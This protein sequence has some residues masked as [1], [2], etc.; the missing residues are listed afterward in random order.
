MTDNAP[1]PLACILLVDADGQ[2]L[3]QLRDE[4][5]PNWPGVWGTPGGHWE[6]GETIE[7]TA[8]RELAEE[9]GLRPDAPLRLFEI[10]ELPE[11]GRVKH[12]FCGPTSA[13]QE[14][15]VVGEGAAIVFV[16]ADQL[17]DGRPY[18]PGTAEVL[19]R[20]LAS[21]DYA[22]LTAAR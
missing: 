2:V 19:A 10:V 12:F 21:P 20:F 6:P 8:L 22:R 3:M 16:P 5:A 11:V 7:Q 17:F 18:T 4:H 15:V 9:T 13:R 14:D 1:I